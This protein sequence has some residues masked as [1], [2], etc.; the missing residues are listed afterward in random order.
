MESVVQDLEEEHVYI[1][2]PADAGWRGLTGVG[3]GLDG[4]RAGVLVLAWIKHDPEA[5]L[6][7]RDEALDFVF[8]ETEN[9]ILTATI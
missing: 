9:I 2:A 3:Q 6:E 5:E 8:Y 4:T 7:R 1:V